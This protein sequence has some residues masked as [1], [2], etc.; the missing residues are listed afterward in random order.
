MDQNNPSLYYFASDSG[1]TNSGFFKSTDNGATFTNINSAAGSYKFRSPCDIILTWDSSN[2]IFVADGV[3]SSGVADIFKSVNGGLNWSK[4]H[5]NPSSSEVPSMCN[6]VFNKGITYATNWGGGDFYKTTNFGT[7]WFLLSTQAT[8]GWASDICHEDPSLVLKGTYGSP[9]YVSTNAG[10]TFTSTAIAGGSGGGVI[11]PDRGYLIA[12]QS[13]GL[14]KMNIVYTFTPPAGVVFT[15]MNIKLSIEGL[16]NGIT[17]NLSDTITAYLRNIT[18]PYNLIDSAK[19]IIDSITLTAACVFQNASSGTY[20][21]EII[22]RNSIETWS[23]LGGEVFT[24]GVTSEY[25]FTS[26]QS[27][28]F[29]NNQVL[30]GSKWSLYSGDVDRNGSVSLTDILIVYNDASSFTTGYVVT[31]LNGDYSVTLTDI[32]IA[33]NNANQFV[34]KKTPETPLAYLRKSE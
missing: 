13:A 1:G 25:D 32:L 11:V 22:H 29:G 28:A 3:T 31:D 26:A 34:T 10:T 33:Y 23:D 27:Q 18:A 2:V 21:I 14:F 15:Q 17:L 24:R 5:T 20:Y 16:Y 4:V 9:T 8:S 19:T 12:M 7:N 6:T 30:I